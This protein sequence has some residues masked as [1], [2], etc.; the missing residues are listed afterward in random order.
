MIGMIYILFELIFSMIL[1][2]YCIRSKIKLFLFINPYHDP[3]PN[4]FYKFIDSYNLNHNISITTYHP[5]LNFSFDGKINHADIK[6]YSSYI[7]IDILSI[8][9]QPSNEILSNESCN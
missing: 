1:A 7:D 8:Q 5:L 3:S 6:A 9:H 4:D 2:S